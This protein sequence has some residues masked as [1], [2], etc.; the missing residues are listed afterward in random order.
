MTYFL[1]ADELELK[2]RQYMPFIY[3]CTMQ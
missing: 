3:A 2:W 1:S